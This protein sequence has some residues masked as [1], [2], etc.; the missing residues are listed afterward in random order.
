M[1]TKE[2][3]DRRKDE[4]RK[5]GKRS[6]SDRRGEISAPGVCYKYS[7]LL[8]Y[9]VSNGAILGMAVQALPSQGC[10]KREKRWSCC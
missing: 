9:S 5:E 2:R 6:Q 1:K 7:I 4:G 8:D 10:G 3:E